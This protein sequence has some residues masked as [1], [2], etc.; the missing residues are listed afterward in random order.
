MQSH[1]SVLVLERILQPL[2]DPAA[3]GIVQRRGWDRD[4]PFRTNIPNVSRRDWMASD[5]QEMGRHSR[6]VMSE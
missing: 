5:S 6:A 1:R 3:P 4:L 2:T